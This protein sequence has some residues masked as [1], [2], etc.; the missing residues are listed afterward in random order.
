MQASVTNA[1]AAWFPGLLA[2]CGVGDTMVMGSLCGILHSG[3]ASD[4]SKWRVGWVSF[5]WPGSTLGPG[6]PVWELGRGRAVDGHD[7]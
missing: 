3:L 7:A 1:V 2:R 4:G 6:W 5:A